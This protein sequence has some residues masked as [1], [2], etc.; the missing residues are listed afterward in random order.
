MK[1][2]QK[3]MNATANSNTETEPSVELSTFCV[4]VPSIFVSHMSGD[5]H[6]L[7]KSQTVFSNQSLAE[8]ITILKLKY[9]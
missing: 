4:I 6:L 5:I 2:A 7:N 3:P 9:Y 1:A 8:V